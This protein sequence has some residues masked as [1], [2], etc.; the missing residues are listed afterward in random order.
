MKPKV[1]FMVCARNGSKGVPNKNIVEVLGKPLIH[2]SLETISACPFKTHSVVSTDGDPI[3][4]VVKEKTDLVIQRPSDLAE[5]DSPRWPVLIHALGEAEVYFNCKYDYVFDLQ[6]TAP[7]RNQWDLEQCFKI[8]Q[9][10]SV[11]NMYSVAE[12]ARNPYFNM[13]ELEEN[14]APR[15]SKE[16]KG[17]FTSR[18]SSPKV[19]EMNAS[20]YAWKRDALLETSE[21]HRD[22]TRV[23]IMPDLRSIDVDRAIDLKILKL[24]MEENSKK[25][26]S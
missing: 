3:A 12:A 1:L 10:P 17:E 11:T 4:S 7:L 8:I 21:L 23:H 22:S 6:A 2:Y 13:V 19:Y 18:Q 15:L 16:L 25:N 14:G 9:T 5:D 26:E 20:I 24:V